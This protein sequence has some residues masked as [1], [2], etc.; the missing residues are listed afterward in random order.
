[1]NRAADASG[2]G[3]PN[4]RGLFERFPQ[5]LILIG[6]RRQVLSINDRARRLLRLDE[7][8]GER[9]WT[10]CELVC[11][12]VVG[13]SHPEGERC[14][15]ERMLSAP[16]AAHDVRAVVRPTIAE[17]TL[18]VTASRLDAED[19][20]VMLQL[21][22]SSDEPTGAERRPAATAGDELRVHTLGRVAVEVAGRERG[23][24]WMDQRP[25][26]LLKYL[27]CERHRVAASDRIAEALW[28]AAERRE[29]LTSLRHYVHVLRQ[30]LE[31]DR[32]KRAT[33]SFIET[34]RGG[35]RLD[36]ERVWVDATELEQRVGRGL[37]LHGEGQPELAAPVLESAIRLHLGEFLADDPDA[38]W[39]LEERERLHGL[40]ARAC[41][42]LVEG[43]LS[44]GDLD[45]ATENARRLADLEPLDMG[46][47]RQL[48]ELWLRQGR[49][50][51]AARRY[52]QLR[53]RTLRQ[54]GEEPD[55]KLSDLSG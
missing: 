1:M 28:P 31:P 19:V 16:G 55:F 23:G 36:P 33:S 25:G 40:A 49:R 9:T 12:A 35:Y 7:R 11:N 47:Q 3:R 17:A 34:H 51:D 5:G 37:Q 14:L 8:R 45:A 54:F 42:A 32:A 50:S 38:E 21:A 29:A 6:D 20:R 4:A 52:E 26:L 41:E 44:A 10:C 15:A 43:G 24:E 18:S 13:P 39:A 46:V 48:I 53:T 27:A 22:R 2:T 30:R